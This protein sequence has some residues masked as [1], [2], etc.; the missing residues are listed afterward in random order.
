[1]TTQSMDHNIHVI[2]AAGYAPFN[3]N[4]NFMIYICQVVRCV[5]KNEFQ[6]QFQNHYT[7][8]SG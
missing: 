7:P 3:Q 6:F 5:M 2:H 1:M 4:Y 8:T